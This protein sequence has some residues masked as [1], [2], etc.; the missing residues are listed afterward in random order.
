MDNYQNSSSSSIATNNQNFSLNALSRESMPLSDRAY[1]VDEMLMTSTRTTP[2][3]TQK[4][5]PGT[6]GPPVDLSSLEYVEEYSHYLM[7]A[8]CHKSYVRPLG[9]SCHH[10]FC[11]ACFLNAKNPRGQEESCPACR[12]KDV[13]GQLRPMPKIVQM[14]LDDLIVRCPFSDSGCIEQMSRCLI[15]DYVDNYCEYVQVRCS[16]DNCG[17]NLNENS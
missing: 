5:C 2:Q 6:F 14:M 16:Y 13:P 17:E 8:I 15:Q 1:T 7:C 4:P 11:N 12:R 9:L 10:V 3:M